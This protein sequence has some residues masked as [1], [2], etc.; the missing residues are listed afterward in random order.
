MPVDL[1]LETRKQV[2]LRCTTTEFEALDDAEDEE[3]LPGASGQWGYE[4]GQMLSFPYFGLSVGTMGMGGM[5]MGGT[6]VAGLGIGPH[7]VTHDRIP[8]GEVEV[9]RGDHVAA[10]DGQIGRVRGL[11]VD[12]RD[13]HVTHVLLDEGHLWGEK[14]VAIPIG[15]V[16][17]VGTGIRLKLSKDEVRDLPPVELDEPE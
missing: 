11:V 9:R 7:E 17:D 1:V 2:Q 3:F 4:H 8:L 6:G 12:P 15:A 5:G 13:H 16:T 14:Q 10:T